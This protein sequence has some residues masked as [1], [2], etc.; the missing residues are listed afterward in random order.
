[1]KKKRNLNQKIAQVAKH[2]PPA[3]NHRDRSKEWTPEQSD[4]FRTLIQDPKIANGL[5]DLARKNMVFDE[6]S[7]LWVGEPW[8]KKL[9]EA[10]ADGFF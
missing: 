5:I 9:E 4:I 10:I 2:M 3:S 7:K 6:E 1:M 8:K